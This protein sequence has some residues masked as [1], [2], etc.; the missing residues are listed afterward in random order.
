M[1]T[2]QDLELLQRAR[3][4]YVGDPAGSPRPP[5]KSPQLTL[6]ELKF[7]DRNKTI[8]VRTGLLEEEFN[9]LLEL[10]RAEPEQIKRGPKLWD[11]DLRLVIILQWIQLGQTYDEL[12]F[13][14][15]TTASR[16]QTAITSLWDPLA[17]VLVENYIP[18]S[19]LEYRSSRRFVNHEDAVGALD[20]TLL[21]VVKPRNPIENRD[22]YSGKHSRH[23]IKLQALVAPDGVCI[24]IGG[25]VE[26]RHNDFYL[27]QQS[28]LARVMAHS[29]ENEFGERVMVRPPILADGGY[30]GIRTTY[31]EAIIPIRRLPNRQLTPEQRES[32]RLL[33]QDRSIVERFFGRLKLYWGI[34][35]RP[36]RCDRTSLLTLAK[37]CVG[38]TNLKLRRAPLNAD[39]EGPDEEEEVTETEQRT[40][41]SD[42]GDTSSTIQT[43]TG[44]SSPRPRPR[45]RK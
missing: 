24:H 28:G 39:E 40:E 31:P 1:G 19:P 33:S 8:F 36:Y 34:L 41:G 32:N 4:R 45:G 18:L 7:Q 5:K 29:E 9:E 26:G 27:Y 14:F 10:L 13:F 23:G 38:L 3:Q 35:Q 17:K 22:Y 21:P 16:I 42:I 37:I 30:L 2:I 15:R 12:A 25:I 20:A 44:Q 11:L 6:Q 43:S